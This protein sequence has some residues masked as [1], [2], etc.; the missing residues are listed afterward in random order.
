M[1]G[2]YYKHFLMAFPKHLRVEVFQPVVCQ[3]VRGPFLPQPITEKA[4][5]RKAW[6]AWSTPVSRHIVQLMGNVYASDS[7]CQPLKPLAYLRWSLRDHC[8]VRAK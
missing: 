8:R 4:E 7:V 3:E 5:A 6:V 2:I 1:L